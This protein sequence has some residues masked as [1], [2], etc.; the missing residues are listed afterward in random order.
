VLIH[1]SK[2]MARQ[3]YED[4]EDYLAFNKLIAIQSIRLQVRDALERG[5][6]VGVAT[7]D[8]CIK[9]MWRTS[10][11]HMEGQFGFSMVDAKPL[12]FIERKG[13]LGFFDVPPEVTQMCAPEMA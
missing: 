9:S 5:G 8:G 7:I 13:A 1:A 4:V 3:E 11:W 2:S 6:I 10:P 12:P